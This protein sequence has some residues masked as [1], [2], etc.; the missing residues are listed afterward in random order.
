MVVYEQGG[1]LQ[2]YLHPYLYD[3]EEGEECGMPSLIW[4]DRMGY[5]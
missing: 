5:C 4:A 2:S 1:I 3:R